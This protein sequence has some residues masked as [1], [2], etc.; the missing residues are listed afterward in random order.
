MCGLPTL[1]VRLVG[2]PLRCVWCDSAYAF[3]GGQR[4]TLRQILTQVARYRLPGFCLTGGEPLAHRGAVDLLQAVVD[5][6]LAQDHSLETGGAFLVAE[7]PPNV[8]RVVDWK[9]PSSGAADSFL[10]ENLT[11]LRPGDALKFVVMT[12][13]DLIWLKDLFV[14]YKLD[15]VPCEKFVQLAVT[16]DAGLNA[17][18]L[19]TWLVDSA[20][21]LRLGM[22]LHKLIWPDKERGV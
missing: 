17:Q 7:V 1:F 5:Q 8:R 11:H 18:Q 12:T 19:A 20:L 22:Q 9:A 2:C 6:D 16:P 4:L 15:E 21:S 13:T 14:R 10:L 3:T